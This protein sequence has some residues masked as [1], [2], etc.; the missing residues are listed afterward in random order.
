MEKMENGN[1]YTQEEE[2][3]MKNEGVGKKTQWVRV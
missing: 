3:R 1:E 2:R